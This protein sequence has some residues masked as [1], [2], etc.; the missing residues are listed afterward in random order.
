MVPLGE[1]RTHAMIALPVDDS[2]W[3][4]ATGQAALPVGDNEKMKMASTKKKTNL[5][6]RQKL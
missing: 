6:E 5:A 1:P 3:L 4:K 2:D